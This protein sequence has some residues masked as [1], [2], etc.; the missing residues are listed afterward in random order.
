MKTSMSGLHLN[1]HYNFAALKWEVSIYVFYIPWLESMLSVRW[2]NCCP[3]N[4]TVENPVFTSE[5]YLYFC[6]GFFDSGNNNPRTVYRH[7]W[8]AWCWVSLQSLLRTASNDSL[9]S[10]LIS[11]FAI[12][13]HLANLPCQWVPAIEHRLLLLDKYENMTALDPL[14]LLKM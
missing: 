4:S 10:N 7:A 14:R 3:L 11:T 2:I 8:K 9:S 5:S 13:F 12:C 6:A 1:E